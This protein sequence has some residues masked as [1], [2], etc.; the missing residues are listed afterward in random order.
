MSIG[1]RDIPYGSV[2]MV[3]CM[4][5]ES[6]GDTDYCLPNKDNT[7]PNPV[8]GRGEFPLFTKADMFVDMTEAPPGANNTESGCAEG[9]C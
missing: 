3:G 1:S 6:N 2:A 4:P 8:E 9:I 5:C 7:A